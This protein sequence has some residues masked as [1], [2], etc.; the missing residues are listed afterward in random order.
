MYIPTTRSD[1]PIDLQSVPPEPSNAALTGSPAFESPLFQNGSAQDRVSLVNYRTPDS[2]LLGLQPDRQG[3]YTRTDSNGNTNYFTRIEGN[4]YQIGNFQMQGGNRPTWGLIN[5]HTGGEILRLGNESGTWRAMEFMPA[6]KQ[7]APT[8]D[9][10]IAF[11]N[12]DGINKIEHAIIRLHEPWDRKT[13]D[14]MVRLYGQVILTPEGKGAV[15]QQLQKTLNAIRYSRDAN[16]A[17][18]SIAWNGIDGTD[19]AG[20]HR[21]NGRIEFSGWA[22][23]N[24]NNREFTELNIHEHTH[25]GAGSKDQW[26]QYSP[27]HARRSNYGGQQAPFTFDN[28]VNNADTLTLSVRVLN[29]DSGASRPAGS[30]GAP[31]EPGNAPRTGSRKPASGKQSQPRQS[32][33][34]RPEFEPYDPGKAGD[35]AIEGAELHRLVQE[36]TSQ[37]RPH[38]TGS[39]RLR[40]PNAVAGAV[41]GLYALTHGAPAPAALWHQQPINSHAAGSQ[42]AAALPNRTGEVSQ[43]P[44]SNDLLQD[45]IEIRRLVSGGLSTAT[46]RNM[47]EQD[48][49]HALKVGRRDA[50]DA[51][52]AGANHQE[53]PHLK[54]GARPL[55]RQAISDLAHGRGQLSRTEMPTRLQPQAELG[56]ER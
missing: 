47:P 56:L 52:S 36:H 45:R 32:L 50:R 9:G 7:Y 13:T 16:G 37:A 1:R 4:T 53:S 33:Q 40:A 24:E 14:A 20:V 54:S 39:G 27:E 21:P 22:V 31:P 41:A 8:P 30:Y 34:D 35:W 18:E 46:A 2:N 10:R 42:A 19:A 38:A 11:A 17:D 48:T 25:K 43:R 23:R 29:N 28:A 15:A 44:A 26:Y 6:P 55:E 5:P 12:D 49:M 51:E 3:I